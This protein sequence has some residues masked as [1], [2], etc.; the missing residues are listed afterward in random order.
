MDL[1]L[2]AGAKLFHGTCEDF[3][4]EEIE[5]GGYDDVI[6]TAENSAIAQNYIPLSGGATYTNAATI[7][8][9]SKDTTIQAVQKLI[10]LEYD[11]SDTKWNYMDQ[12]QSFK[13]AKGWDRIPS[14]DEIVEMMEKAGFNQLDYGW[15]SFEI[16]HTYSRGADGN[17]VDHVH[18]PGENLVGRLFI[19]TAVEPLKVYDYTYGGEREGDLLNVDYHNISLFRKVE[20]L[21]YDGIKI[22]D[23]AQSKNWGNFGHTSIGLFNGTLE[24]LSWTTIPAS[25]FDWGDDPQVKITPE[26]AAYLKNTKRYY[27]NPDERLREL[28]RAASS[29]DISKQHALEAERARAGLCIGCGGPPAEDRKKCLKCQPIILPFDTLD[30]FEEHVKYLMEEENISQP[31][32]E[33]MAQLNQELYTDHWEWLS[34]ALTEIMEEWNEDGRPWCIRGENLG[35][36]R[37]SGEKVV[38]WQDAQDAQHLLNQIVP[39]GEVNFQIAYDGETLQIT[40]SHHDAP[41]GERY[42]V[43]LGFECEWCGDEHCDKKEFDECCKDIKE[44][45]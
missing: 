24:K 36:M 34:D 21:G 32:A 40:S 15:Q 9:P 33:T 20:A 30:I 18:A 26:Y 22:N 8:L 2:S 13:L 41:T 7:M 43:S 31:E 42:T 5:G 39:D 25:N 28:E 23:F 19:F 37:R 6:W 4:A 11:I 35:W 29:G 17:L 3:P 44:H 14:R 27:R 38:S 45:T 10:G 12:P 1:I 16:R